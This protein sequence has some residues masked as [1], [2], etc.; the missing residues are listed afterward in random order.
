M[1]YFAVLVFN[2]VTHAMRN[3]A[4]NVKSKT[5]PR[6]RTIDTTRNWVYDGKIDFLDR[7]SNRE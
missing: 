5:V 6:Q 3:H 1:N 7:P 4:C 2:G